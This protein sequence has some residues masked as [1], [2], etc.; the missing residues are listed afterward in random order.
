[1]RISYCG[2][3]V[4][5]PA[6]RPSDR[7]RCTGRACAQS[8]YH[9][10]QIIHA[11][12]KALLAAMLQQNPTYLSRGQAAAA[13]SWQGHSSCIIATSKL[14]LTQA[15]TH[16]THAHFQQSWCYASLQDLR[17][18]HLNEARQVLLAGCCYA[19]CCGSSQ[20]QPCSSTATCRSGKTSRAGWSSR[21]RARRMC[22]SQ[23]FQP[24]VWR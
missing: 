17:L 5:S 7:K 6:T 24:S 4:A 3:P 15:Q 23:G 10:I 14:D 9:S 21:R 8:M 2:E 1:M 22:L 20:Q 18:T 13:A 12:W 16:E 19:G 11:P